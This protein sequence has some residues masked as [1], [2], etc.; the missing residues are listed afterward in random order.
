MPATIAVLQF[1]GS[2]CESET[3]RALEN[4]RLNAEVFRWNQN[5]ASLKQYDGVIVPGGFSYEDR[6]R[7]GVIASKEALFD[8]LAELGE[9]GK[10]I[11]GICNGAQILLESGLLPGLNPGKVEMALAYNYITYQNKVVR[12]GHHCGWVNLRYE[13]QPDRTPFTHLMQTGLAF[14]ITVSHGEGRFTSNDPQMLDTLESNKQILWRYCTDE[15]ETSSGLPVNPNG[16]L[17]NIAGICNPKG[18]IT[19]L[20]PHPERSY[21]L[22]Q[23]P[24]AWHGHWGEKRRAMT[25]NT[26]LWNQPGPGQ[27]FFQSLANWLQ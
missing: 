21:Y 20:M 7:A 18:N 10:P 23:I 25:G 3:A 16:S 6:V 13:Q 14:P 24:S 2:N 15:G 11:L 22:R 4:V 26:A 12:R 17:S 1:P 8:V 9:A 19:A 27:I 5:P